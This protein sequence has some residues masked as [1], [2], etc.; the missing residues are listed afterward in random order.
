[1]AFA[2]FVQLYWRKIVRTLKKHAAAILA[3]DK[4]IDRRML[5]FVVVNEN[6]LPKP[7]SAPAPASATPAAT[8]T[9]PAAPGSLRPMKDIL[10]DQ[11]DLAFHPG[12]VLPASADGSALG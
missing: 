2:I 10:K 11:N 7:A 12:S 5:L 3:P 4:V 9:P 6:N 8:A 1:M